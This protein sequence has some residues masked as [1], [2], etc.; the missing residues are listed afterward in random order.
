MHSQSPNVIIT[1]TI[2]TCGDTK[3]VKDQN[4]YEY[5]KLKTLPELYCISNGID[6]KDIHI[7]TAFR[8]KINELVIEHN[9]LA[10]DLELYK[11][12]L[13]AMETKT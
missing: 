10:K 6:V 2:Q 9:H 12:A 11:K 13:K 5:K 7:A 4:I 8:N 3:L 1:T